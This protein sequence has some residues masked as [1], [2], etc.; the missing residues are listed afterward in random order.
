MDAVVSVILQSTCAS[1]G[2]APRASDAVGMSLNGTGG[3]SPHCGTSESHAM[4]ARRNRGGVPVFSRPSSNPSPRNIPEIPTALPSPTRPPSVRSS[5]VCMSA[6][7]NVP[8]VSTTAPARSSHTSCGAPS[9]TN[10]G[11]AIC[12]PSTLRSTAAW[13][14]RTCRQPAGSRTPQ[15]TPSSTNRSSTVP[16]ITCTSAREASN[17]CTSAA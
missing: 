9:G 16:A 14:T 11:S 7:M 12:V 8:V 2:N 13:S 17:R 4:L 15:H 3:S 5:P 6:R 10:T 1:P